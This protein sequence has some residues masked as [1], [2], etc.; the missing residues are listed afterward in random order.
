VLAVVF[1]EIGVGNMGAGPG[2]GYP[3]DFGW[4]PAA[5]EAMGDVDETLVCALELGAIQVQMQIA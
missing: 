2:Y 3:R 5:V 1:G 4:R